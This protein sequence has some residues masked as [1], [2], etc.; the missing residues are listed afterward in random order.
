MDRNDHST[1][2]RT[3]TLIA[4]GLAMAAVAAIVTAIPSAQHRVERDRVEVARFR[5]ATPSP[6]P[7]PPPK[8]RRRVPTPTPP[9]RTDAEPTD[10]GV[11][12]HDRH[13]IRGSGSIGVVSGAYESGESGGE[14]R[15]IYVG[16]SPRPAR[17]SQPSPSAAR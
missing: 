15:S 4:T 14:S 16:R 6:T 13:E 10:D 7:K 1:G 5:A 11:T 3:T 8:E 12:T 9:I 17:S 2:M